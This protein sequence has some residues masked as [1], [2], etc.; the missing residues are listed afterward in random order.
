MFTN[1]IYFLTALILYTTCYYPEGVYSAPD[2]ALLY[3]FFTIIFF[4][5]TCRVLFIRLAK[6]YLANN[7]QK[8]QLD[9]KIN[10]YILKLSILALIIYCIDLYFFKLKLFLSD[11]KIFHLFPTLQAVIFLLLFLFYLIIIWDSAWIVQHRFFPDTVTR[12]DFIISNISFSLPAL[13]PWFLLSIIADVI[14]ILPF[15]FLSN[16]LSTA[17]GEIFY[18]MVFLVAMAI[19]GPL[20]I[21]KLWRCK[22]LKDGETRERIKELCIKSNCKYSDILMWDLFGG[23]MITAGVMGL[24]SRFRYLLVT[25]ALINLLDNN[26]VDAVISHEIGHV[27][28]HHLYFYVLFFAGYMSCVYFLFDPL[29]LLI[30]SSGMLYKSALFFEIN[31]DTVISIV[32]S[33]SLISIFLFYFRYVFGFFMRNFERQ[34]DTYVFSVLGDVFGLITTFYK[35]IKYSGQSP[36]K[37]NWHHYS[38]TERIEFLRACQEDPSKIEKHNKKIVKIII[39][40][41]IALIIVCF[42]GYSINFGKGSKYLN[43]YIA[44]KILN[45]NFRI[46][47]ENV[48]LYA[49]VGDYSFNLKEF[50]NAES[51]WQNVLKIDPDNLH[52]LNNLAWLYATS[53]DITIRNYAKA[54]KLAVKAIE[55]DRAPY[56]LD[57]YAEACM[58]NNYCKKALNASKEALQKA[59]IDKKEYFKNQYKRIQQRCKN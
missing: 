23:T 42:A 15:K 32:F 27:K 9:H 59:G 55:I 1:F 19:F 50:H 8:F 33:L 29:M 21:Q 30:Y 26:E 38:I 36:D 49:M 41:S 37:P 44:V 17:F 10:S 57:T 46:G 39:G 11:Y 45:Q 13:I 52:A 31:H 53:E 34:A 22:P 6:N 40:F 18:I 7:N 24:I 56:I 20:L 28:K 51:A 25:P 58:V 47:Q 43:K 3:A 4:A 14:H 16:F 12:K 48:K 5:L 35:I 2:Y 54:Y